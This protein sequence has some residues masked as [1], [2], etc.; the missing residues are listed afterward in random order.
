MNWAD[1]TILCVLLFSGLI[2]LK[3][4]FIKEALSLAVW[5][6]ALIVAVS[7]K[8]QM[9]QLLTDAIATPSLRQMA[10]FAIL[11]IATL[12]IGGLLNHLLAHLVSVTGL[13]GTDRFLGFLFGIVRGGLVIMLLV[14][15]LPELIPVE[16]DAWW[17]DSQLIPHFVA[18]KGVT[19]ELYEAVR[20]LVTKLI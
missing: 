9:A 14:F 3:N 20:G 7:F 1:I 2:S 11:F 18:L 8:G 19:L 13:T 16:Q 4:G 12:I 15:F 10:A 5:L 6:V 17:R